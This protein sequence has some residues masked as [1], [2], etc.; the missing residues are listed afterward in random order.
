MAGGNR[1]LW[2]LRIP[3]EHLGARM[4][5]DMISLA[6]AHNAFDEDGRISS[7]RLQQRFDTNIVNFMDSVDAFKYYPCIKRAWVEYLGELPACSP[8][9][10]LRL[11]SRRGF[12]VGT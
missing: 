5:P 9:R 12:I 11:R 1:G 8:R 4:Y 7:E 6:Q 3:F 2:S 10:S